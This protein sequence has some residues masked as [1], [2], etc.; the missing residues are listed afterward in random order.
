MTDSKKPDA[1]SIDSE[2]NVKSLHKDSGPDQPREWVINPVSNYRCQIKEIRESGIPLTGNEF[3][4]IEKSAFDA[5][6]EELE[7]CRNENERLMNVEYWPERARNAEKELTAARQ[8]IERF[9]ETLKHDVDK[10][11]AAYIEREQ[12]L[13]AALEKGRNRLIGIVI[14]PLYGAV[15]DEVK[16]IL[17]EALKAHKGA[18]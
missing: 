5:K 1:L 15:I 18:E 6:C 7:K 4:V 3:H 17:S 9:E 13:V 12:R 2:T 14:G 8:E 10:I 11:E 16:D